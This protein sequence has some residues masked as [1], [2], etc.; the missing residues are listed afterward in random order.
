MC[1]S[2][3]GLDVRLDPQGAER[4]IVYRVEAADG[5]Q[6]LLRLT[7]PTEPD[8]AIDF[9]N[10]VLLHISKRCPE[11]QIPTPIPDLEGRLAFRPDWQLGEKPMAR[12]FSWCDGVLVVNSRSTRVQAYSLGASL[13]HLDQALADFE[14]PGARRYSR[15]D[16]RRM[17]DSYDCIGVV[18]NKPRRQLGEAA[19]ERF[20]S[21]TES[22]LEGVR[23]QV[24]HGDLTPY[25]GLVAEENTDRVTGIIDFG[26]TVK[27]ALIADV[28]IA[29]CYFIGIGDD[30]ADPLALP[31]ALVSGFNSVYSLNI[32]E[33]EIIAPLM[34]AR[35]ALT[36]AITEYHAAQ[37][38]ENKKAITKNTEVAW[39]GLEVLARRPMHVWTDRLRRAC[40]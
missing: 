15:W 31:A 22:Q 20:R 2:A 32:D 1:R 38:P 36:A 8:L 16:M 4:D 21:E 14:H 28:A 37:R 35:H 24:V 39:R 5:R 12:L 33:I 29:A 27:S 30:P 13:A 11:I 18:S 26:D 7:D 6:Y 40:A 10:A 34:E 19:F 23:Q 3:W 17:L 25:N 9:Q